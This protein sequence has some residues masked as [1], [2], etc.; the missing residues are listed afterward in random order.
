MKEALHHTTE[1]VLQTLAA[2]LLQEDTAE[3]R[4][5]QA[6]VQATAEAAHQA[7]TEDNDQIT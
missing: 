1:A 5:L 4:T 6:V 2:V 7:D 3:A